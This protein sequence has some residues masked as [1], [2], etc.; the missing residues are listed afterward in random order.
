MRFRCW[1]PSRHSELLSKLQ[2]RLSTHVRGQLDGFGRRDAPPPW[3]VAIA[4]ASAKTD[5]DAMRDSGLTHS[6]V[7]QRPACERRDRGG[8]PAGHAI[9]GA[10][11]LAHAATSSALGRRRDR[12]GGGDRLHI[13]DRRRS[14][15]SAK[16]RGCGSGADRIGAGAR[17]A[18]HAHGRGRGVVRPDPMAGIAHRPQFPDELLRRSGN[19]RAAWRRTDPEIPRAARRNVACAHRTQCGHAA[20][21]R[22][23]HRD[24][25]HADRALSFPSGRSVRGRLPI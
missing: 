21:D 8:L 9:V 25:T 19:R 3:P 17:G 6:L 13:I 24:R 5:E 22:A 14:A 16:L 18:I 7:D 4:A 20:A 12:G 2:R 1:E 11:V 15:D 10:L 23:G